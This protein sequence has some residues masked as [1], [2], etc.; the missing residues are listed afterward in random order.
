MLLRCVGPKQVTAWASIT[1]SN[2]TEDHA[3]GGRGG[4]FDAAGPRPSHR[5]VEEALWSAYPRWIAGEAA[6]VY[7][8]N[9]TGKG[10]LYRYR[11][12]DGSTRR[13]STNPAAD[14]RDPHGE[15]EPC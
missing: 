15:A 12:E 6:V 9:S 3:R 10:A 11:L 7:H 5:G 13:V 1:L 2:R 8:L 4:V 14:Y